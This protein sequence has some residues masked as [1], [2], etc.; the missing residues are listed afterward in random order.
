MSLKK[1]DAREKMYTDARQTLAEA[2][3]FSPEERLAKLNAA[4]EALIVTRDN[5]IEAA[6]CAAFTLGASVRATQRIERLYEA[7]LKQIEEDIATEEQELQE[8]KGDGKEQ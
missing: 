2:I 4:R 6:R 1:N 5:Q 7:E 8:R 3:T